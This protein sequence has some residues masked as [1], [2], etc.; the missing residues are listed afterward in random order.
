MAPRCVLAGNHTSPRPCKER[1]DLCVAAV[2]TTISSTV[3]RV[4]RPCGGG[5]SC[6]GLGVCEVFARKL[7]CL[8]PVVVIMEAH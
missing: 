6:V 5:W 4:A 8:V 3:G 7:P 1:Q 2:G